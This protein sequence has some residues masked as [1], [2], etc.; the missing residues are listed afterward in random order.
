MT[1]I[2]SRIKSKRYSYDN[3]GFLIGTNQIFE[4]SDE[5]GFKICLGYKGQSCY[6]DE[7]VFLAYLE[8]GIFEE[9]S[10]QIPKPV[11]PQE[12]QVFFHTL[13]GH[14]FEDTFDGEE[15]QSVLNCL[16]G[17]SF[18]CRDHA[19][20]MQKILT[21]E[22]LSRRTRVMLDLHRKGEL[23]RDNNLFD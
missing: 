8:S 7:E 5:E 22:E 10:E 23:F 12:G 16:L 18:L 15:P 9:T 13:I 20:K 11:V 14:I 4:V 6:L 2:P 3:R 1:N 19:E 17:N 21:E